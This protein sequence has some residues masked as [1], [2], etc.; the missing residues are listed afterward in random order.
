MK[1][2]EVCL[3]ATSTQKAPWYIVP[4]DDKEN[5]H[6][7]ISQII[8]DTLKSLKMSYPKPDAQHQKDLLEM[9]KELNC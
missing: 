2:Y 9:R 3:T 4:A 6:L 8:V 5:A 7:I 1:A